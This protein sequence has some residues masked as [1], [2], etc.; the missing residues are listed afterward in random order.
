M[1]ALSFIIL[2]LPITRLPLPA[3]CCNLA[4]VDISICSDIMDGSSNVNPNASCSKGVEVPEQTSLPNARVQVSG[5]GANLDQLVSLRSYIGSEATQAE[6]SIPGLLC[7]VSSLGQA[8][9][10]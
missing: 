9:I 4:A 5:I 10:P 2:L 7:P 1:F 6:C 8:V 3:F